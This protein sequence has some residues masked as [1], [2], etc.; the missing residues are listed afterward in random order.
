MRNIKIGNILLDYT[1]YSGE[2]LYSDGSIEDE[3]LEFVKS[4]PKSEYDSFIQKRNDWAVLYHL[5]HVRENIISSCNIKESDKVLEIGS[6]CGAITGKLCDMSKTVTCIELSEKRSLINAYRNQE[7][8][9]LEIMLGNFEVV[10]P[11]LETNFDVITLIGVF[12]YARLYISTKNPYEDFLKI[13]LKHL[14]K[15]GK[16]LIAIENRLGLKYFAGCREDHNGLFFDGIEGYHSSIGAKTFSHDEWENLL[17]TQD[18]TEYSFF[19]PY[20]DYKF[21]VSIY[22]DDYLPKTGELNRNGMNFDRDRLSLF[23]ESR[24]FDSFTNTEYF[25]TFSNSFLIEITK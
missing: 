6:G 5:S 1:H 7:K 2:D 4:N 16:L 11:N 22:S 20:P 13:S 18:I 3:I 9:N 25:K 10:E 21:P 24:A 8:N 14:K 23:S 17:K 15:G 19:Y 12:E